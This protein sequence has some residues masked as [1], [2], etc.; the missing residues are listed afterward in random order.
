MTDDDMSEYFKTLSDV[1]I[2]MRYKQKIKL[3][4]KI[5]KITNKITKKNCAEV[6]NILLRTKIPPWPHNCDLLLHNR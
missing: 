4:K 5:E 6:V 3:L 1:N 2:Q